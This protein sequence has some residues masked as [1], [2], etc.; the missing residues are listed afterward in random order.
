MSRLKG[1]QKAKARKQKTLQSKRSF[2]AYKN[3]FVD[4]IRKF[5]DPILKE[6]AERCC[7]Y[8]I[9]AI[10]KIAANLSR[11]LLFCKNGVGMAA[12]QIGE[13][14]SIIAMRFDASNKIKVM[15]DP[16]ITEYGDIKLK[17]VEG[18]LSYPGYYPLVERSLSI[19]VT[20]RDLDMKKHEDE[21]YED[22][23]ARIIQHECEH[24]DGDCVVG[25]FYEEAKTN[26]EI[27][28]Q[29][30]QEA[31]SLYSESKEHTHKCECGNEKCSDCVDCEGK[32]EAEKN[33]S[34]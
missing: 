6:K 17:A 26:P 16:I 34:V 14:L 5:D 2:V 18:C 30:K 33:S 7:N 10:L 1:K 25:R 32:H 27:I 22:M 13:P 28:E 8:D 20:Y 23:E 11:T 15:I 31:I 19:K 3:S 12:P 21:T 24:L 29:N 4:N 9:D